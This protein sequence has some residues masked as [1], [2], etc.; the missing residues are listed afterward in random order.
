[1]YCSYPNGTGPTQWISFLD[2][3][4]CTFIRRQSGLNEISWTIKVCEASKERQRGEEYSEQRKNPKNVS[5][6]VV[7][8]ISR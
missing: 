8:N 7:R 5:S 2:N 6:E 3:F 1:M 4:I